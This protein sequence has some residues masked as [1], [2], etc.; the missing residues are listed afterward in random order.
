LVREREFLLRV[1]NANG[2]A[3]LRPYLDTLD[4]AANGPCEVL[5]GQVDG[6]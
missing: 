4:A 3:K 6:F 1:L 2:F 5:A